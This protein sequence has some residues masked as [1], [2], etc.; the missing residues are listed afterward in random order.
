M[1]PRIA[2]AHYLFAR[3][4]Q[5]GVE[6]VFGVPG[7][8]NIAS[9]DYVETAGLN[10]AGNANELIAAY[11]ADGY[12]RVKGLS[13]LVT[14]YGV[15]ELSA[16][17]AIAGAYAERAPVVHI[18]GTPT[19]KA[20]DAH[21][22]LHHTLG[23]GNF[24][25]FPRVQAE[26][27]CFQ[28]DLRDANQAA[29]MIDEAIQQ[30]IRHSRPVY[31]GLPADMVN[32]EIPSEPLETPIPQGCQATHAEGAGDQ[33]IVDTICERI[34]SCQRPM[35]MVDGF[36]RSYDIEEETDRLVRTTAFS[37]ATTTTGKGLVNETYSNFIGVFAGVAG[38]PEH[39]SL[40][41]SRDLV[42]HLGPLLCDMNTYGFTA[43]P[44]SKVTIQFNSD[45][46]VLEN[47]GSLERHRC[48]SIK[49][50]LQNVV[51]RLDRKRIPNVETLSSFIDKRF[52]GFETVPD[53]E[54]I[55]QDTFWRHLSKTFFRSTDIILPGA[56]TGFTAARDF[57]LPASTAL[58]TSG[59]WLSIGYLLGACV[60]V[61]LA[62][63]DPASTWP[64]K[65]SRS[66]GRTILIEGD[67][68]FQM[69]AQAVSDLIR[70]RLDVTIII[71][72]NDGY[73]VERYL[74]GMTAS[75]NDVQPWRY[76]EAASYFG[77]PK[78]DVTYPTFATSAT[79]WGE[80]SPIL[81]K[82]ADR[83]GLNI[84]EIIMPREDCPPTLSKLMNSL[85]Q[86][87]RS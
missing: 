80:L 76:L 68:S 57:V 81:E 18:V 71:I 5:Q 51:K 1:A 83:R 64:L 32:V 77:A 10:W 19:T 33:S 70:N 74:H 2:I 24:K 59:L 78:D 82:I 65:K 21:L 14:T 52:E 20:Q 46:V 69:T 29:T 7:D 8:F 12:A 45:E 42:L 43:I 17:N 25:T 79:T 13:A 9:L 60:G 87:N 26:F 58:I 85:A 28:V 39:I 86:R 75:Y 22:C 55:N 56:G 27:T 62:Q 37:T 63:R 48:T 72:N 23:D 6:T 44:S 50:V 53:A 49:S 30:C 16:L 54:P 35:I 15:G 73:T 11:A 4:R 36:V 47:S 66:G 31:V 41:E 34:Y 84:V 38:D 40:F 61:A 3:L 67:G